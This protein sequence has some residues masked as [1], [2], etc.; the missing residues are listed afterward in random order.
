MQLPG[1]LCRRQFVVSNLKGF[2]MFQESL[3]FKVFQ[4]LEK[5]LKYENCK[6]TSRWEKTKPAGGNTGHPCG[7]SKR[8]R[9]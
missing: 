2:P 3:C 7:F 8:P 1:A 9:G 5:N 4:I 6:A